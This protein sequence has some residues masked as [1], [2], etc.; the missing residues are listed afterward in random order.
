MIIENSAADIVVHGKIFTSEGNQIVESFAVKD[1]KFI[2][3]GDKKGVENFIEEGKAE[4]IDYTDKSYAHYSV[5]ICIPKVGTAM[6]RD[7][8][9]EQFL[10][11][12]IPAA[13][14][15]RIRAQ[16]LYW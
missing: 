3:V 9:H 13:V 7:S 16:R 6:N 1:G 2:Y 8:T 11:K 14:K 4:I 10:K 12:I 5:G 15:R